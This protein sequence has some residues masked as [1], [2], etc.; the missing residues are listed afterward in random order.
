MEI[1]V[2]TP[3]DPGSE[4]KIR[5]KSPLRGT[6]EMG[7]AF[8]PWRRSKARSVNFDSDEDRFKL[9]ESEINIFQQLCLHK[10]DDS[11]AIEI[12]LDNSD[13]VPDLSDTSP[14]GSNGGLGPRVRLPP[15]KKVDSIEKQTTFSTASGSTARGPGSAAT[16][17]KKSY[18]TSTGSS[19]QG[20]RALSMKKA[21]NL[22]AKRT[23][24]DRFFFRSPRGSSPTENEIVSFPKA[25][26]A[27]SPKETS[28]PHDNLMPAQVIPH[29]HLQ[30]MKSKTARLVFDETFQ[31]HPAGHWNTQKSHTRNF[32]E[33]VKNTDPNVR[34][35]PFDSFSNVSSLSGS[36]ATNFRR[37]IDFQRRQ[38][39]GMESIQDIRK[40]LKE[41]ETQLARASNRGQSVSRQKLITALFTVVD[42]LEDDD[43]KSY[44]KKEL[45]CETKDRR[46]AGTVARPE[47]PKPAI[48]S[49]GTSG[50][51]SSD[52]D[53]FTQESISFGDGDDND[54]V[55][56]TD[57]LSPFN[58][59]SF[60]GVN[61]QNQQ[62][63]GKVLDDLFWGEFIP[64]RNQNKHKNRYSRG[65]QRPRK[66]YGDSR[67]IALKV[68]D[69]NIPSR[70]LD[71]K[72]AHLGTEQQSISRWR[73]RPSSNCYSKHEDEYYEDDIDDEEEV[74]SSASGEFQPYLPTS[75]TVK[76][77]IAKPGLERELSP[78]SF[79]R[80]TSA[81]HNVSTQQQPQLVETESRLGFEMGIL[82]RRTKLV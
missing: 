50:S 71:P 74:S 5:S 56:T 31:N 82:P 69:Y 45:F 39:L 12:L 75:I 8:S 36:H 73:T 52:E 6:Q 72:Q 15:M 41:M 46:A 51:A 32:E 7:V 26:V 33:S 22:E 20:S 79:P 2:T 27:G 68:K 61:A 58:I 70:N 43:E 14:S 60:F 64:T 40:C 55:D 76:K 38:S 9:H 28:I 54:A 13:L 24:L 23:F 35:E 80:N 3:V 17:E 1:S 57:D 30:S 10:Y 29:M 81:R 11:A 21:S 53:D 78:T 62:V 16:G 34:S 42:S 65:K 59:M 77:K 47:D 44:L 48:N 66:P 18:S 19:E 25:D 63:V 49:H 67:K 37:P 4:A